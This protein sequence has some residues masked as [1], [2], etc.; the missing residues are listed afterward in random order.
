QLNDTQMQ[1]KP[2]VAWVRMTV[3]PF[4]QSIVDS[5]QKEKKCLGARKR[6]QSFLDS[7]I[8]SQCHPHCSCWWRPSFITRRGK[9][10]KGEKAKGP[11]DIFRHKTERRRTVMISS[12]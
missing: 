9:R 8:C 7:R 3:F 4:G 2:L 10:K 11:G 12:L 5:V 6:V 1:T